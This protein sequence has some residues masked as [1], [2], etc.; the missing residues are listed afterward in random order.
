MLRF[1]IK[2]NKIG[3]KSMLPRR[4]V[5]VLP[6]PRDKFCHDKFEQTQDPTDVINN[7]RM[8]KIESRLQ[9]LETSR[10]NNNK[11]NG[12]PIYI[13]KTMVFAYTV[14]V[15]GYAVGTILGTLF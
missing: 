14:I 1:N 8:A 12:E 10:D 15:G 13:M 11:D 3:I 4:H 7:I 2:C 6:N 9:S 5:L